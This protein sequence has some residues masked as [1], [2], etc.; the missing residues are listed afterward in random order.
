[1]TRVAELE[2]RDEMVM[3]MLI[4][5]GRLTVKVLVLRVPGRQSEAQIV[6]SLK[7]LEKRKLVRV[8]GQSRSRGN[9]DLWEV[10]ETE[11]HKKE[12]Q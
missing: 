2:R 3:D 7:R 12:T 11:M 6:N 5:W 8:R 4:L 10:N 9:P 1:M